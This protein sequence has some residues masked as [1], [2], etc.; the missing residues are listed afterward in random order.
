MKL[1]L[2]RNRQGQFVIAAEDDSGEPLITI[3][4]HN[5]FGFLPCHRQFDI[6]TRMFGSLIGT[7]SLNEKIP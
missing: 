1:I 3:E 7:Y 6:V 5:D 2:Y 4:M